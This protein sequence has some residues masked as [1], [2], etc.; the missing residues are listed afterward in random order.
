MRKSVIVR[1][2]DYSHRIEIA[3]KNLR[4]I[5]RDDHFILLFGFSD[6]KQVSDLD[7]YKIF[8]PTPMTKS[9]VEKLF[10]SHSDFVIV[11]WKAY[12]NYDKVPTDAKVSG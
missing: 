3:Q 5:I 2:E 4:W 12:P 6:P 8:T 9:Q 7:V 11:D 1:T 10:Q